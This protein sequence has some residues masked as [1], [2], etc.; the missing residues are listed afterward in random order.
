VHTLS[1]K[2]A[3]LTS[4]VRRT[5]IPHQPVKADPL[6]H[7]PRVQPRLTFPRLLSPFQKSCPSDPQG[8]PKR[9]ST[10]SEDFHVSCRN[11]GYLGLPAM[12]HAGMV[13]ILVRLQ[14]LSR[15]LGIC[16]GRDPPPSPH[17]SVVQVNGG[18]GRGGGRWRGGGAGG[19]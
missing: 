13:V 8:N 1:T 15:F 3:C 17:K 6:P 4:L 5:K 2:R 18:G 10:R 12:S 9:E 19:Q 14:C 16:K 11:G 7:A